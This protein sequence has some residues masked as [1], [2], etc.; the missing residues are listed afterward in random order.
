MRTILTIL[1][2]P[3]IWRIMISVTVFLLLRE[4][5][6][7]HKEIGRMSHNQSLVHQGQ[8]QVLLS[9]GRI[10]SQTGVMELRQKELSD[11]FPELRKEIGTLKVRLGNVSAVSTISFEQQKQIVAQLRDSFS[12][13]PQNGVTDAGSNPLMDTL[14]YNVFS[15]HDEFYDVSGI[16]HEGQQLVSINS[17]DTMTQVVY[18]KRKNPWLWIFSPK[19]LEQRVYFKNPNAHIHYSR[20]INIER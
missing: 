5:K 8:K 18:R 4:L 19:E 2:S 20:T 1:K 10:A 15:Y 7:M 12:W 9:N 3:L 17:R 14:R 6:A 16:A 11:L 13:V